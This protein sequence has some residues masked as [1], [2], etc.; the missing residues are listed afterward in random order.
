MKR[1][2]VICIFVILS[3]LICGMADPIL[4]YSHLSN[5]QLDIYISENN[6]SPIVVKNIDNYTIIVEESPLEIKTHVLTSDSNGNIITSGPSTESKNPLVTIST[7][8]IEDLKYGNL[9]YVNIII[10][11][12]DLLKNANR[13]SI[14]YDNSFYSEDFNN[15]SAIII[16]GKYKD[17]PNVILYDKNEQEI[18]NL[19]KLSGK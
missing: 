18:Y 8:S 3:M 11:D 9:S 15:K 16:S 12:K 17:M 4:S 6:L 14:I 13:T 2:V 5:K 1:I 7:H 19:K 10:E